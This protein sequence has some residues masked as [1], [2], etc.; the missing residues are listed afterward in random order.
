[1]KFARGVVH[2]AMLGYIIEQS[3]FD[4]DSRVVPI[5][6]IG[7]TVHHYYLRFDNGIVPIILDHRIVKRYA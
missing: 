6:V 7:F 1:L 3:C 2:D 5:I 4:F